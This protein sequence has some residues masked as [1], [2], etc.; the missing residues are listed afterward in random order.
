MAAS[1]SIVTVTCPQCGNRRQ[2]TEGSLKARPIAR[3]RP[4]GLTKHGYSKTRLYQ[5]WNSM[6]MRCG[7][8]GPWHPKHA[9]YKDKGIAVCESWASS[10]MDF[11]SWALANGYNDTLT[12]D[13]IDNS[14]CYNEANCRWVSVTDNNR[15]RTTAKLNREIVSIIKSELLS[16]K[17]GK[18]LAEKF[19]VS[20]QTICDI[21]KRRIWAEIE[22]R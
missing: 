2:I 3:C 12:I 18:I 8:S 11:R 20:Q 9:D 15:N 22:P 19:S 1:R 13:R 14:G 16:G 17:T 10:F 6:R 5:I 7:H 21:R 4:C